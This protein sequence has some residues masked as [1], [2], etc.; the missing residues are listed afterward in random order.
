M[1]ELHAPKTNINTWI[2]IGGFILT[3]FLG[4]VAIGNFQA[5][6]QAQI[7]ELRRDFDEAMVETRRVRP[8]VE[9]RLRAM[10]TRF[11]ATLVEVQELKGDILELKDALRDTTVQLREVSGLLR[12]ANGERP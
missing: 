7:V 5:T 9:A 4:A 6:T 3:C 11:G 8:D 10:E 2:T 1:S 12:Q